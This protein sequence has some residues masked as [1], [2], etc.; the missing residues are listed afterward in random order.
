VGAGLGALVLLAW[1]QLLRMDHEMGA[2]PAMA[3]ARQ[4]PWDAH[5]LLAAF[6]MWALMMV[7]MMLPSAAPMIL[8]FATINRRRSGSP[9]AAVP[10]G[11]F[12][13]GYLVVWAAFSALAA[14]GQAG[15]Q[16]AALLSRETLMV[17]PWLGGVFLLLAGLW[18][19]TPL[20]Y[21][22]LARCQSPLGFI[23][24]EW[25]E[26]RDGALVMGLRHGLFC[27]G[28]CWALM[29]LLFVAGV[30]NLLWVAVLAALVLAQKLLPVG[31]LA[32]WVTGAALLAAGVAVLARAA[33]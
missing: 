2:G 29:G 12:V 14:L 30:M 15:L 27:L 31:R 10:T 11:I 18:E 32:G 13:A 26:G 20:K 8:L 33:L 16:H 22:C 21:A 1:A 24:T 6:L 25:R 5:D 3:M 4:S 17:L 28:C 23:M 19:L 9:G 7:A